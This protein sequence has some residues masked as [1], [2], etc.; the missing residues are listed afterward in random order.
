MRD[1]TAMKTEAEAKLALAQAEKVLAESDSEASKVL[2]E[3]IGSLRTLND[4]LEE[5]VDEVEK[6]RASDRAQMNALQE[7]VRLLETK[8]ARYR[9]MVAE[10]VKQLQDHGLEPVVR[11]DEEGN[12]GG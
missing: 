9:R 3:V 5:R 11:P 4:K 12:G 8:L 10:L 1:A 7:K 6:E 2:L